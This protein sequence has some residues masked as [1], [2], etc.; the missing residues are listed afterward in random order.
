MP[1]VGVHVAEPVDPGDVPG[2][3]CGPGN[4]LASQTVPNLKCLRVL[5]QG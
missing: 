1:D 4:T 2:V 3:D 5:E